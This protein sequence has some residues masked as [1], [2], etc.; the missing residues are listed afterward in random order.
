MKKKAAALSIFLIR[1]AARDFKTV[2]KQIHV[3]DIPNEILDDKPSY[4]LM[5]YSPAN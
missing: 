4:W 5:A 3:L 2:C 1:C